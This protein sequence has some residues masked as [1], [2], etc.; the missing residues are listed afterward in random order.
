MENCIPAGNNE[1]E[2]RVTRLAVIPRGESLFS[3]TAT[4]V[5]VNDEA[6]GEFV[7]VKGQSCEEG[8]EE[9]I[10][11]DPHEWSTL[12]SA[13]DYMIRQCRDSD[14]TEIDGNGT[15]VNRAPIG[16]VPIWEDC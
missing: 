10:N 14:V 3:H 7:V 1:V 9:T 2:V 8:M 12:R 4:T 15:K 5:S 6:A 16:E 13:I 11:I